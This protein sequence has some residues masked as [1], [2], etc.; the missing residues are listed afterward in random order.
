MRQI[1]RRLKDGSLELVEV[2]DPRPGAGQVSV[3]VAASVVSAGTE[4]ATMEAAQK[5]LLAKARARPEQAR[6][7]LDRVLTEGPRSTL[8]F[9]RQRLDELGPL[10]Y[11]AA[12]TVLEADSRVS[13]IAPGDR[14]AIGGGDFA[15]HAELDVVPELLCARVPDS[16]SDEDAA[17]ATLGAIALH[18]FRRSGVE[19]GAMVAV[20]GLG[21]I[22]QLVT[23]IAL[24]AGCAVQGVDLDPDLAELA[25]RAGAEARVREDPRAAAEGS[26][27]A[28]LI[29]AS[30]DANDPIELAAKL[31]RDR[32]P[33]VVV[34]AVRM[35]IPRGPFYRKELDLRLS[36]SYGPGRYDPAYE[37]HG[38]DYPPGYVPWTQQRN[39]E[40]F[41]GL[42][43][44]GK[45]D[46]AALV[47]HRFA[48]DQAQRAYE[49]LQAERP[50]AIVLSYPRAAMPAPA[51]ESPAPEAAPPPRRGA[52]PPRFGLIGAGSFATA[53]IIPGLV[54]AGFEPAV[55][56]S[57]SGLSAESARQRFGFGAAAAGA[58]AVLE[59][60]DLELIAIATPHDSHAELVVAALER[61]RS[62]YVEKPLAL[63]F[64][65]VGAIERA[66]A[67][68]GGHLFVGF[69]R[70]YAPLARE[71]RKLGGPRVMSYRVNAGP[72]PAEHWTNDVR[73]GGGRL[74][75]EGCH[76]IDFLCDQS[77]ADPASVL[78][79]G[80][81]SD[82]ALALA[83]TDNFSLQIAFADGS[84]GTVAYAADAPAGPGKERFETSAPG[85]Y[86]V[87]EDFRRGS[88]WIGRE[89]R[90]LGGRRQDKGFAAQF[91]MI[92]AVLRG[93][94]EAPSA[95]RYLLSTLATLAAAR[96]LETGGPERITDASASQPSP[97]P[98]AT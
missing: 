8:E 2:P 56:A 53:K 55:V 77:G 68:A 72:L 75:G 86:A 14:V 38:H 4:R 41:L 52:G 17:F 39:M 13:R 74:K 79:S 89:R 82:P 95:D 84:A 30:T 48:F 63:V 25:R 62:V 1:A 20:I 83:G 6:Q 9:V 64:E 80:F 93:E 91:E 59:D 67:R 29:C 3:R 57:A 92:S 76:F 66:L 87:I 70:R 60:D 78:C 5:S 47:S 34:G 90:Q 24:A 73:R 35:E 26:A 21:L 85:A 11:S 7:V 37:L 27:D 94:A 88:I 81:R 40:A 96:S 46:P 50:V 44:T 58:R 10:G 23:R 61:G 33:V 49:A 31:A 18:G 43:A 54:E 45:L 65:E 42:V 51:A 36:R 15:N 12:G 69:N 98:A 28:V 22:G 71:L 16:V 32:A 97:D 19:V